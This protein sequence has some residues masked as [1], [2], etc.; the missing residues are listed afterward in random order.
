MTT[1]ADTAREAIAL[2][3]R[4]TECPW[5]V[6]GRDG[7]QDKRKNEPIVAANGHE[8]CTVWDSSTLRRYRKE[9]GIR[10]GY[11]RAFIAHASTGYV[12]LARVVLGLDMLQ[13]EI[14]NG[15]EPAEDSENAAEAVMNG[16]EDYLVEALGIFRDGSS[17]WRAQQKEALE[18]RLWLY[19]E[20]WDV[21]ETL[22]EIKRELLAL[23]AGTSSPV[24]SPTS[25]SP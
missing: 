1:P 13:A 10:V 3:E 19:T 4:V 22:A 17:T 9:S 16:A 24:I 12:Q 5:V 15:A 7:K 23:S 18:S 21:P 14:A 6:V 25:S 20:H 2:G 8:V 11:D